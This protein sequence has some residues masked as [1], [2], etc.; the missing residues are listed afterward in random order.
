MAK[1]ELYLF[2]KGANC[3]LK[4]QCRRYIE[5]QRIDDRAPGYHWMPNCDVENRIAFVSASNFPTGSTS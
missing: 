2:C 4:D 3:L 5:G 1:N